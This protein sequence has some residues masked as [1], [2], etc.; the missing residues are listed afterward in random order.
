M[1]LAVTLVHNKPDNEAQIATMLSLVTRIT[2]THEEFDQD[3]NVVGSFETY[4]YEFNDLAIPHE[5]KF[6]HVVPFGIDRP[7]NLDELDGHKVLYGIEDQDKGETRFFNWGLKRGTDHGADLSIY[8][9]DVDQFSP[10]TLASSLTKLVSKNDSTEFVEDPSCKIATVKLLK[11]VG[12]L[13]EEKSVLEAVSELKD[14]VL[15]KGMIN[16]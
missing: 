6:Y 2:D 5:V 3:G 7:S 15:E 12:Q 14:R 10:K 1:K 13:S 4:H 11:E 16:G 8:I 9:E